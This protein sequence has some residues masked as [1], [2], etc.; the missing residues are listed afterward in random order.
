MLG[1]DLDIFFTDFAE[2]VVL[3]DGTTV[4]CIISDAE[5][6]I[7][8]AVSNAISIL[9]KSSDI[10]TKLK[11]GEKIKINDIIYYIIQ[12][13][14]DHTGLTEIILTKDIVFR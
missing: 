12:N 7:D 13:K 1:I 5:V 14:Q 8:G 4:K 11:I 3:P 2:T 10:Q 6:E 9:V